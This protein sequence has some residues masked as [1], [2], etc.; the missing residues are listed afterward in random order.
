VDNPTP[1]FILELLYNSATDE[2]FNNVEA[3]KRPRYNAPIFTL[4]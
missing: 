1:P 3:P 4:H 2:A